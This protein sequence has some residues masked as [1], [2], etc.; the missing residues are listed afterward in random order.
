MA[1]LILGLGHT[2][3]Q[4]CEEHILLT[5]K[6]HLYNQ[7]LVLVLYMFQRAQHGDPMGLHIP[8]QL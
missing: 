2:T 7:R 5:I 8:Q 6:M 1:N 4:S 3:I